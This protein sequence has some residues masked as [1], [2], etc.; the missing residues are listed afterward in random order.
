MNV[1]IVK[2]HPSSHGL[3]HGIA[4][5]YKEEKE[6]L[7]SEVR[8]L[9]LY[10]SE[11]YLDYMKFENIREKTDTDVEVRM[12]EHITWANEIVFVHPIWWGSMP[13]IMK[14]FL[15]H[16]LQARFAFRYDENKN[17]VKML[18][19]KTAKVFC[20]AGGITWPYYIPGILPLR[21]QWTTPTLEFCGIELKE[22]KICGKLDILRDQTL[23]EAQVNQF[24]EK[25]RKSA[26]QL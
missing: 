18:C 16:I 23:K 10:A 21:S 6:K 25:V 15:E 8:T 5:A 19:G 7:G 1:L 4:Q 24:L 9:D 22:L 11:N 13:A 26:R 2:A 20:T 14:N 3:T 17:L 12:K